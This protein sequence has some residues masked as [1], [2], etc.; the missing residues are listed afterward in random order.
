[1]TVS[2]V[3]SILAVAAVLMLARGADAGWSNHVMRSL[4]LGW[5]D[6]YHSHSHCNDAAASDAPYIVPGSYREIGPEQLPTPTPAAPLSPPTDVWHL[7]G[8]STARHVPL[9]SRA[10]QPAPPPGRYR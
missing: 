4:G 3:S 9:P 7:P 2:R 10:A 1:V 6:G 5:S 8:V